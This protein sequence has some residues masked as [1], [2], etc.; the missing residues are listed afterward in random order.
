[1]AKKEINPSSTLELISAIINDVS[2]IDSAEKKVIL[3][4][5][6]QMAQSY[7]EKD[8]L[9]NFK[10]LRELTPSET[11][12]TLILATWKNKELTLVQKAH[13]LAKHAAA[14]TPIPSKN[15]IDN[16]WKFLGIVKNDK[17]LNSLLANP[18]GY[19]NSQQNLSAYALQI[20][21]IIINDPLFNNLPAINRPATK[22]V[23]TPIANQMHQLNLPQYA[24]TD[25][26]GKHCESN[27]KSKSP[28]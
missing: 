15:F 11:D 12:K 1:M 26:T 2:D 24:S 28:R 10:Q 22:D 16:M 23:S 8:L 9:K 3:D 14:L 5:A 20:L 13:F 7:S 6:L 21:Q 27:A 19:I 18:Q 4:T 25:E 17:E